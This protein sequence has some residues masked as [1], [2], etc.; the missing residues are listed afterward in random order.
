[1]PIYEYICSNC[2][3]EEDIIQKISDPEVTSCP[4][5]S[6]E[7]LKKIVSAPSFRLKG[8]GWYETDFKNSGSKP[9]TSESADSSISKPNSNPKAE[10]AKITKTEA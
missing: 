10:S 9:S 4:K 6:T 8:T 3:H 5:C 2:N 1:M 7:K